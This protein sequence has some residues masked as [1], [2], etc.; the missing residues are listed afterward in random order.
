MNEVPGKHEMEALLAFTGTSTRLRQPVE[1]GVVLIDFRDTDE[2]ERRIDALLS[3][4]GIP[5]HLERAAYEL[6][7]RIRLDLTLP[8]ENYAEAAELLKRAV[9][10]SL[11]DTV[12][13]ISDLLSR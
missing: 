13:G 2:N 5:F 3:S 10:F 7:K 6:H 1:D 12:A 9:E 11:L 4:Q 8:R